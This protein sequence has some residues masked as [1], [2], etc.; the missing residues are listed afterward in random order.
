MLYSETVCLTGITIS[1]C[2]GLFSARRVRKPKLVSKASC[3]SLSSVKLKESV[4]STVWLYEFLLP[5]SIIQN[6]SATGVNNSA[7]FKGTV[8]RPAT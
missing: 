6:A 8:F 2:P 7:M 3:N 4:C 1:H 5:S